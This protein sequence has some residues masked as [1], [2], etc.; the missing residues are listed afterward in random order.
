[1]A[2][3][4]AMTSA[5]AASFLRGVTLLGFVT[6]MP[7]SVSK[8]VVLATCS[9]STGSPSCAS[10]PVVMSSKACVLAGP[11]VE[12]FWGKSTM[13]RPSCSNVS[14]DSLKAQRS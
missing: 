2:I 9:A 12:A 5:T 1:M 14:A 7:R 13:A 6:F 3:A 10:L 4:T 11:M 8:A